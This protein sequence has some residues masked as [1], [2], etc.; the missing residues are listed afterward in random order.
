MLVIM[1]GVGLR[2]ER[3]ANAFYTA[4]TPFLDKII[5]EC[6]KKGL[7]TQLKAHGTA[8]GLPTDEEMGNSEVGHNAFGAGTVFKQRALLSKEA[9]E[10]KGITVYNVT[11]CKGGSVDLGKYE[12]SAALGK[13]GVIGGYDITTESAITKLMYLLGSGYSKKDVEKLLQKP[14]RGEM[15]V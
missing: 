6:P 11:Q 9:I 10:Q 15:S 1:D 8:V 5:N 12:T 4:N 13:I 2:N 7:Y 3:D 14:L